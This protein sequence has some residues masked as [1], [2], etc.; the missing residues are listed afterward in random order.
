M[1]LRVP[2]QDAICLLGTAVC[3]LYG[4][5]A[6]GGG[7]QPA[8]DAKVVLALGAASA[9]FEKGRDFLLLCDVLID[10]QT[11]TA[12]TV[13]SRFFS[14]F[15]G[16]EVVCTDKEGRVLLRQA[17]IV[18]Q[19]PQ[20]EQVGHR[21]AKGRTRGRMAFDIRDFPRRRGEIYVRLEGTLP[22]SGY[23]HRVRSNEVTVR[24]KGQG[25]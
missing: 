17:Y 3:L 19:S 20:A 8:R 9:E 16:L 5:S 21:L 10:N 24:L 18:H 6:S 22:G 15:D 2:L 25:R 13:R 14:V 12:F 23:E 1:A 7:G 11:G 4:S